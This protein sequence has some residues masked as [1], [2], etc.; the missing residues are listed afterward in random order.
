MSRILKLSETFTLELFMATKKHFVFP[1]ITNYVVQKNKKKNRLTT[2]I[3][4]TKKKKN[5]Y[6]FVFPI[7]KSFSIGYT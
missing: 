1:S 4:N 5:L 7:H 2:Q 3:K 6:K